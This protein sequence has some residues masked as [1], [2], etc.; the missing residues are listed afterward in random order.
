M[1]PRYRYSDT[2]CSGVLEEKKCKAVYE[3]TRPYNMRKRSDDEL[4]R[5]RARY[6]RYLYSHN[7]LVC[8]RKGKVFSGYLA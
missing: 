3:G 7:L 5:N 4:K 6:N 2:S 8:A 1:P